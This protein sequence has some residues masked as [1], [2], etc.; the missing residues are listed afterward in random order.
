MFEL[1]HIKYSCRTYLADGKTVSADE[2]CATA[3]EAIDRAKAWR[4]L[5]YKADA[6][7][8]LYNWNFHNIYH[9]YWL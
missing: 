8:T 4:A 2:P 9:R 1:Q 3:Q 6:V 5:G 7:E